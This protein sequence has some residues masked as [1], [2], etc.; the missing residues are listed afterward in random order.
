VAAF[1]GFVELNVGAVTSRVAP[2]LKDQTKGLANEFPAGSLAP[3]VIVAVKV[4]LA[5]R[6]PIGAN[7]AISQAA[8]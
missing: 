7:V 4:A 1:P 6:L 8:L 3:V 2:V 5:V